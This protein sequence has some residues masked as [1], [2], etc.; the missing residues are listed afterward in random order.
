MLVLFF[1]SELLAQ[2]RGNTNAAPRAKI[3][4]VVNESVGDVEIVGDKYMS[5]PPGNET[6]FTYTFGS[7]MEAYSYACRSVDRKQIICSNGNGHPQLFSVRAKYGTC[8]VT[9][10]RDNVGFIKCD[11]Y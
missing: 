5:M 9:E 4:V 6:Q 8:K 7:V 2:Y 1:S 3:Y 10:D 11:G